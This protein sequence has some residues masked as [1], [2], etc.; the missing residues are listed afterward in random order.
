MYTILN[1]VYNTTNGPSIENDEYR[2]L[3][4]KFHY[5]N[6][7]IRPL[8]SKENLLMIRKIWIMMNSTFAKN[9]FKDTQ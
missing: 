5:E 2:Q 4:Q 9:A 6:E 3:W 7:I 8:S 1:K